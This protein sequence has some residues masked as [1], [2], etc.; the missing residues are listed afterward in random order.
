[1]AHEK[2]TTPCSP[3]SELEFQARKPT[4]RTAA[5]AA[6]EPRQQQLGRHQLDDLALS[7][8]GESVERDAQL[9]RRVTALCLAGGIQLVSAIHE[10]AGTARL[11][12]RRDDRPPRAVASL[13]QLE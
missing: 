2:A 10:L 7:G 4:S 3:S 8:L 12:L 5:A 1:M 6:G 9:A 13:E 11:A